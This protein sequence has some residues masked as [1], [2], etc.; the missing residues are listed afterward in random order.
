MLF[1][2]M[3]KGVNGVYFGKYEDLF[4]EAIPQF[5]FLLVTFGYMSLLIILK[6]LTDFTG[7]DKPI[8]IIQ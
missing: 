7:V 6:W 3:L 4:F 8:S 1:G 2:I 5:L